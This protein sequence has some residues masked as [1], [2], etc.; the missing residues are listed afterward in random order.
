MINKETEDLNNI[1][2]QLNL[3]D[4]HMSTA[5]YKY[6]FFSSAHGIFST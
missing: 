2:K 4:I 5:E 3:T 6:T 1:I